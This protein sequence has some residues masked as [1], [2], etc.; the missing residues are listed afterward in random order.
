MRG[1]CG[2]ME[3]HTASGCHLGTRRGSPRKNDLNHHE[4]K[5]N[6]NKK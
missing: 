3:D 2:A 4:K 6:G 1:R 5:G